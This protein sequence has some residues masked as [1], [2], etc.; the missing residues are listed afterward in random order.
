MVFYVLL[1]L[2][3]A[4]VATVVLTKGGDEQA[5][6]SI[7][8]GYDVA[9]ENDCLGGGAPAA[10]GRPLPKTAPAQP[11]AAGPSFDVKQ[12]GVFV[13]ISNTQGT[14]SGKL[15]L[16]PAAN[17]QATRGLHGDVGCVDG[18]EARFEGTARAR[19]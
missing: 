5:Q 17:D 19:R 8:G 2:V 7:A 4:V 10:V 3:T 11:Q 1:A 14:L 15:R 16:E 9:G 12:S 18:T 13:N 6:P